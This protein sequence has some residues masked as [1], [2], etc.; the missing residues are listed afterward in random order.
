MTAVGINMQRGIFQS[1]NEKLNELFNV[2]FF[3]KKEVISENL[4]V[5]E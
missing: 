2:L 3:P 4:S 1:L 5:E